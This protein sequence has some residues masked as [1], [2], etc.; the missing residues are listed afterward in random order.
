MT[1]RKRFQAQDASA[2]PCQVEGG[3]AA[4]GAQASN[5]DVI[6]RAAR[7][8]GYGTGPRTPDSKAETVAVA[9]RWRTPLFLAFKLRVIQSRFLRV[10]ASALSSSCNGLRYRALASRLEGDHVRTRCGQDG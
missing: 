3:G 7:P 9:P 5:Y 10:P 4:H 6:H 2:A 8:A 1:T